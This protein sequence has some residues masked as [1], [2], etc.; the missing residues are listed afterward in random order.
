MTPTIIRRAFRTRLLTLADCP[1]IA[2]QNRA[3]V[4]PSS[5]C[6]LKEAH[7]PATSALTSFGSIGVDGW[8][9]KTGIYQVTVF[10]PVN[11]DTATAEGIAGALESL[12]KPGT[13]VTDST[14]GQS[15]RC[16]S[17]VIAPPVQEPNWFGIPVSIRYRL[18]HS[19]S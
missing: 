10:A 2:W 8:I 15:A 13:T 12:F 9:E 6:W 7:L 16:E 5:G 11:S 3:F 4:A 14:S 19:N 18:F 1:P 17:V